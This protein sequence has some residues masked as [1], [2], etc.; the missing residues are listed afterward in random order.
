MKLEKFDFDGRRIELALPEHKD[1]IAEAI[2]GS[3][4]FYESDLLQSLR[5]LLQPGDLVLDVGANIGNHTVFFATV[6]ECSVIS[7]EP[8]TEALALLREN[9]RLN[10]ISSRVTVR[11]VAVGGTT[12]HAA[13]LSA[14]KENL[15][16]TRLASDES[17]AIQL[18]SL[19]GESFPKKVRLIKID[20]EG[21][22]ADVIR[23]AT[24]LLR[25]SRPFVVCEAA[26][27]LEYAQISKL[28][29]DAGY[30]AV[31]VFC[32]TATY[33]FVPASTEDEIRDALKSGWAH[34]I[35]EYQALRAL[36][37]QHRETRKTV[38][39]HTDNL[40][41]IHERLSTLQSS[42]DAALQRAGEALEKLI[43]V[44]SRGND[45]SRQAELLQ[46]HANESAVALDSYRRLVEEGGRETRDSVNSLQREIHALGGLSDGLKHRFEQSVRAMHDRMTE[47]RDLR[48]Q[49]V[50]VVTLLQEQIRTIIQADAKRQEDI[51]RIE[52]DGRSAAKDVQAALER[53]LDESHGKALEELDSKIRELSDAMATSREANAEQIRT[54]IQW[55]AQRQEDIVRIEA[56]ARSAAK[57]VQSALELRL[58]ESH[59]K[60]LGELNSKF[61]ELSDAMATV[62]EANARLQADN[63]VLQARTRE[64]SGDLEAL[65]SAEHHSAQ[66]MHA[67]HLSAMT[68]I[69]SEIERLGAALVASSAQIAVER[70]TAAS[71]VG[72]LEQA[73]RDLAG[74][75]RREREAR[76]VDEASLQHQIE[77]VNGRHDALLRGRMFGTLNR[78]K[79]IFGAFRRDPAKETPQQIIPATPADAPVWPVEVRP[80]PRMQ[81][82]RDGLAAAAHPVSPEPLV[83]VVMT[84]YNSVA[85]V[86]RAIRSM[87][88]QDHPRIELIVVDDASTDATVQELRRLEAA[89]AR[90][91]VIASALNR[92]TY[93]SKNKG[94][95]AATGELITF[96]DSDD[97]CEPSRISK[98]VAALRGKGLVAST[99]NYVRKLPNGEIVLNRGLAERV[100]LISLMV[101]RQVFGEVGYFDSIRT[102]A[103]DEMV[104]RLKLAYGRKALVNV[105]EPLYVAQLREESLST[106]AGNANNLSATE[107]TAFLS[108]ARLHFQRCYQAWHSHVSKAGAVP[109]V[110]FPVTNR[111]F[112]VHGKL[113]IEE[114]RFFDQPVMGF[115]ASFP[116]RQQK[117]RLA[118]ESLLPQLDRLYIYLNGYDEVPEF[119]LDERIVAIPAAKISDLRDNGKI[120][121]MADAPEGYFLTVDD[122]IEYPHDYAEHL[123]RSIEEY[124][125]R[126]IVGVHGVILEQPLTRYFSPNRKVFSFKHAL[127]A[128]E[129]VHLLGTGTVAFHSSSLRPTL[130]MFPSTGMADV[131]M[132]IAAKRMGVR[133]VAVRR[134]A[135][136]LRPITFAGESDPTLFDE[137]RENDDAQTVALK[138]VGSWSLA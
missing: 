26:G 137:F 110:P 136:W 90:V 51:A 134:P 99:C 6:A 24:E 86:A 120:F 29:L 122:D 63:Q 25:K 56:D 71:H 19:D 80:Q 97:V 12:G 73:L 17:G 65:R 70:S 131:W 109:Y 1:Y 89:D 88:E 66:V 76:R 67:S 93:W 116:A 78:V 14:D 46:A 132:A 37:V 126:S 128:D 103:D 129:P 39:K 64:V 10:R 60:A 34:S 92:G 114:R 40:H 32:A 45:L 105:A 75:L 125:R 57:D 106:E 53:R 77:Y 119:L 38:I 85:H 81:R 113:R 111:P 44:E 91:R 115:M 28:L 11:P 50:S 22:D 13:I 21:M 23:G 94:V 101:K 72:R 15:G 123:V 138:S 135:G 49:A 18:V 130:D 35:F 68:S 82:R 36:A 42:H 33:L 7:Y 117:L 62:R 74:E 124:D 5:A 96:M 95:L 16:A 52:A 104:E 3:H 87:L 54:I 61:R 48:A 108:A 107:S 43:G 118:V 20:A 9:I 2:T 47:E 98:Q 69:R 31:G 112:E 121:H 83:S 127:A 30:V 100:A 133:M 4:A 59:G 8:M 84:T 58:D 79:R 55:D 27:E 102:S 41:A